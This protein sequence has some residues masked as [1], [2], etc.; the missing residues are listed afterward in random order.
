MLKQ[1]FEEVMKVWKENEKVFVNY[2][3]NVNELLNDGMNKEV[4]NETYYV[5]GSV[6]TKPSELEE[7]FIIIEVESSVDLP[8]F[9]EEYKEEV[10]HYLKGS[11]PELVE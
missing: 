8:V 4:L 5:Y 11:H 6:D 7:P 2:F 1:K 3:D 9:T 10:M